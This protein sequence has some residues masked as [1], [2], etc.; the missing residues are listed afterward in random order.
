MGA[1]LKQEGHPFSF[2]SKKFCTKPQHSSTYVRELHVITMAVQK[3]RHYLLGKK[4]I[5]V[6]DQ[7]SFRELMNQVVQ[8]PAQ[9]YFL[10]K[11]LGY[12]YLISYKPGKSNIV[13]D[14][15]SRRD[16][17]YHPKYLF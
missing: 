16:V 3:W 11:P 14:T 7:K 2:F 5:I 10:T 8:T 12:N 15:L 17:P 13:A 1:V 6:M 4:F 9:H